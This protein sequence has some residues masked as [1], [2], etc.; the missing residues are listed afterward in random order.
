M[1]RLNVGQTAVSITKIQKSKEAIISSI[2]AVL[3][4]SLKA[5][6]SVTE[7]IRDAFKSERRLARWHCAT[8]GIQPTA[9]NTLRKY[10]EKHYPGGIKAFT[11]DRLKLQKRAAEDYAKPGSKRALQQTINRLRDEN[12]SLNNHLLQFSAQYLDLLQ[13]ASHLAKAH[14]S[15]NDDLKAHVRAYPNAHHGLYV[16]KDG[17]SHEN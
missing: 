7:E 2:V 10:V 12:R 4:E 11:R 9:V 13:K 6:S 14:K 5:P 16:I 17:G 3:Q 1:P 15:L 8:R